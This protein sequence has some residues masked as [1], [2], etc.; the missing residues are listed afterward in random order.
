LCKKD[1]KRLEKLQ[2]QNIGEGHFI[3]DSSEE[4]SDGDDVPRKVESGSEN[5]E[6][7]RL[8]FLEKKRSHVVKKRNAVS[9]RYQNDNDDDDYDHG[10]FIENMLNN[11][12]EQNQEQQ[13]E[14]ERQIREEEERQEHEKQLE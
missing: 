6:D 11:F 1:F 8:N 2:T 12:N 10:S 14:I 13:K 9:S 7:E 5:G 3:D 4:E